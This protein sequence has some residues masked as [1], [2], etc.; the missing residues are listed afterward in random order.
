MGTGLKR[1]ADNRLCHHRRPLRVSSR[2][3][4]GRGPCPPWDQ[5]LKSPALP[6][7]PANGPEKSLE[8]LVPVIRLEA[9]DNNAAAN[10]DHGRSANCSEQRQESRHTENKCTPQFA[11]HDPAIALPSCL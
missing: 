10:P 9:M 5:E 2:P 8:A 3:R 11:A 7:R 6:G 1:S 4:L